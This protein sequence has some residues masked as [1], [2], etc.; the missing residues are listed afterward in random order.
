MGRDWSSYDFHPCQFSWAGRSFT[1]QAGLRPVLE[2]PVV[3]ADFV[4]LAVAARAKTPLVLT[5]A[6]PAAACSR[7]TRCFPGRRTCSAGL[8]AG[9]AC[10][11]LLRR[12]PSDP[13]PWVTF[14]HLGRR[15][16]KVLHLGPYQFPQRS[17]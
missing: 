5:L 4:F 1:P 11:R 9:V 16:R 3:Y 13:P 8:C 15:S 7:A 2:K 12:P 17:S 10:A 6:A 14:F